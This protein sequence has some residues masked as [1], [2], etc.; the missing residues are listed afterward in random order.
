MTGIN[1][2]AFTNP[3]AIPCHGVNTR[4]VSSQQSPQQIPHPCHLSDLITP[5][6]LN[7][8]D[9]LTTLKSERWL[10]ATCAADMPWR[11]WDLDA[12]GDNRA[13]TAT[14]TDERMAHGY[15]M[16]AQGIVMGQSIHRQLAHW[17][18]RCAPEVFATL[19]RITG[20]DDNALHQPY[21]PRL[22]TVYPH[23]PL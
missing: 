15:H 19:C 5:T 2:L 23:T 18:R 17:L 14:P 22:V 4:F 3:T 8:P 6:I 11:M 9:T 13:L 21:T 16:L 7:T 20:L 1:T 12:S 10:I